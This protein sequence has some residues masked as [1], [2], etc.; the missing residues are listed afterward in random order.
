[1]T[2][3]PPEFRYFAYGSNLSEARLHE[4]CPSARLETTARLPGYRLAFTRRSERWEGGVADIRP[5]AG[6]EVQGVV[7]RID[8]ADGDALD[9]QEGVDATPPR[10]RRIEVA[11]TTAEG[12]VRDCLAYQVVEPQAAQIAPSAAY[13]DTML[14]GARAAGLSGA[15][16]ARIETIARG[17]TGEIWTATNE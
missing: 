2:E 11:V 17:E 6:A 3:A 4:S 15:Y 1:M 9:R 12:E 7:W 16:V 14:R 13:L 10:Y 5:D 8:A